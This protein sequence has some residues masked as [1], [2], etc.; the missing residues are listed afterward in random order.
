MVNLI[1]IKVIDGWIAVGLIG[2][3]VEAVS[4]KSRY[5]PRELRG[6]V[7]RQI[8]AH[9]QFRHMLLRQGHDLTGTWWLGHEEIVFCGLRRCSACDL[10]ASCRGWL[11]DRNQ[12]GKYPNFCSI[13]TIFDRLLLLADARESRVR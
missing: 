7:F 3:G 6:H 2:V 4:I 12:P 5:A 10:V 8:R 13:S 11:A 9:A 1:W